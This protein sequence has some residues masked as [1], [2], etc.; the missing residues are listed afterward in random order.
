MVS[1][2]PVRSASAVPALAT[3]ELGEPLTR[4]ST[5]TSIVTVTAFDRVPIAS[6]FLELTCSTRCGFLRLEP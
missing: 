3:C 2:L 4:R 6:D 1:R 5:G